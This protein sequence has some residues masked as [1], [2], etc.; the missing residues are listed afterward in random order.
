MTLAWSW[1]MKDREESTAVLTGFWKRARSAA[2]RPVTPVGTKWSGMPK[3]N[4][5]WTVAVADVDL[6][7]P[8]RLPEHLQTSG[9]LI[10]RSFSPISH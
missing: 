3:Y 5:A 8:V 2:R 7:S 4:R 6:A 1:T 9:S 10:L